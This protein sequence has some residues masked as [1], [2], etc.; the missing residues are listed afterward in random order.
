[1]KTS[2]FSVLSAF[3]VL[4][5]SAQARDI[6]VSTGGSNSNPG[7]L[8][9]PLRSIQTAINSAVAGDT[10]FVRALTSTGAQAVYTER[11][12]FN[13]RSGTATAPITLC[14]YGGDVDAANA[15]VFPAIDL[16]GIT[17]GT[18]VSAILTLA[19]SSYVTVSGLEFR[20]YATASD[21][22]IPAGIYVAGKGTGVRLVRNKVHH[23]SQNNTVLRN[24][25]ANAFGIAIYGSNATSPI[26]GIVLDGN[27]VYSLRTGQSES[28][29]LNG[30]VTNFR[31]TNNTVHDCNNIGIDCIGFEQNLPAAV[32]YARNGV[33]SGN[34]VYNIDSQYNPGY[35]GNF[36][37]SFSSAA[38]RNATRGAPGIY[39]DGGSGIVVECNSIHDCNIGI[40][41][42]SE[43]A[44]RTTSNCIARD[45]L[46]RA[47]HVGGIFLG[48]ASTDNGSAVN[49]KIT[50]NT[51]YKNDSANAGGGSIEVQNHVTG[52]LIRQNVMVCTPGNNQFVLCSG[53]SVAFGSNTIDYNVYSGC[54]S[55]ALEFI[56]A[57]GTSLDSFAGWKATSGQD[58]HSLFVVASTALFAAAAPVADSDF[59]LGKVSTALNAGDPS[60]APAS[61]ETDFFGNPRVGGAHVDVGFAEGVAPSALL[62]LEHPAGFPLVSGT[63]IVSFGPFPFP[64]KN[65]QSFLIRNTGAA[66]L[67]GLKLT[68]DGANAA[69]FVAS[70]VSPAAPIAAGATAS[71]S[72][73][74]TPSVVGK[75]TAKLHVSS[76][77]AQTAVFT[78]TLTGETQIQPS[79]T[80]QPLPSVVNPGATVSFTV[81]ASG[82]APL[83]YQWRKDTVNIPGAIAATYTVKK[84]SEGDQGTYD[85]V[86][87][88]GAGTDT[89]DPV[90][91]VVN[92][93]VSFPTPLADQSVPVGG[94]ATFT[95]SVQG[96]PPFTYQWRKN[97]VN[98]DGATSDTLTVSG[99]TLASAG[100]YSVAVKNSLGTVISS[101]ASL[102]V[103]DARAKVYKLPTGGNVVMS[104]DFAGDIDNY[105]WSKEGGELPFDQRLSGA[106]TPKLS[107]ND[108][109]VAS[110]NDAGI[111]HCTAK[112]G[113]GNLVATA[114]LIVYSLPPVITVK[115]ITL[116][117]AIVG[118]A[119]LASGLQV[120]PSMDRTPT[121]YT[122]AG[123]PAGL[124]VDP[125]NGIISGVPSVSITADHLYAIRLTV[126]N[127]KGSASIDATLLVKVLPT[128]SVGTFSGPVAADPVLNNGL[129]GR[130]DITVAVGGTFTGKATLGA[131]TYSFTSILSNDVSG[132]SLPHGKAVIKRSAPL[133]PL[134]VAFDVDYAGQALVNAVVTDQTASVG[135][136]AWRNKW[137][138]G[139]ATADLSSLKAIG[140]YY[141]FGIKIPGQ[142]GVASVPQG[143]GYGAFTVS[144]AGDLAITGR[145]A[146][147]IAYTCSTF[148]GP[149]GEVLLFQAPYGAFGSICGT[150]QL[151]VGTAPDHSDNVLTGAPKW[152]RVPMTTGQNYKAGF[153]PVA[154]SVF[155]GRYVAPKA[156]SIILGIQDKDAVANAE[157]L[158]TQGGIADTQLNPGIYVRV[159]SSGNIILQPVNQCYTTLSANPATGMVT[160]GFQLVDTNPSA[161]FGPS[162]TRNSTFYGVIAKDTDGWKARGYFLLAKRPS[163]QRETVSTT[164][165]L[166]GLMVLQALSK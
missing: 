101:N 47:N 26:D 128:G 76:N 61:G 9:S 48:G 149:H 6:Y 102:N 88:N 20:N 163:S 127:R 54:L 12:V 97:G 45:N 17:P 151:T 4:G 84:A 82:T 59:T 13:G 124:T 125:T 71:F 11:L 2:F 77:S 3:W 67:T 1:M 44:G 15:P 79:V 115:T 134:T 108:L 32:N 21:T 106:I 33:V 144:G 154:T 49:C 69:E 135:F 16:T 51:L 58:A 161:P 98:I 139:F 100:Q 31:V 23:I 95:P 83:T 121:L 152:L 91:L 92:D 93:P 27:E 105:A 7:T 99:V 74:F 80:Q 145:L 68:V 42:G 133:S 126:S 41:F 10:I 109:R 8:A 118:G 107:I 5:F 132:K 120:D 18:D 103:V 111:Y 28:V 65:V 90:T 24:A 29:V 130:M 147:G 86:V 60:F 156:P 123:L 155:G 153:G 119:Y 116:P 30:N 110:P 43:H 70:A 104:A 19:N 66:P 143:M 25:N 36:A 157:L 140:G 35:G 138:G 85:V 112:T 117:P 150:L 146:D 94:T 62:Q 39:V 158:F 122:G 87:S 164:D 78:V 72:V 75:R 141:T 137:G 34:R 136:Q 53:A 14:N 52:T 64:G 55:T 38:A 57:G 148:V 37:G 114:Q 166:S 131:N 56:W 165:V 46:I 22:Q 63:S 89:S 160:G 129:G 159:Q 96:M 50:N 73:T 113:G 81:A 142:E 40:S 162:I